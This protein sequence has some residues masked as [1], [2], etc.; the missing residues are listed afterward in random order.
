[1]YKT[2]SSLNNRDNCVLVE[3]DVVLVHN[4]LLAELDMFVVFQ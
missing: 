4:F 2:S 1:M 3:C